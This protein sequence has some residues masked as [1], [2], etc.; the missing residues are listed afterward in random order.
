MPKAKVKKE[1]L[2]REINISANAAIDIEPAFKTEYYCDMVTLIIGIG[3]DETADLYMTTEAWEALK[4]G[5]K[6][7]IEEAK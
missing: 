7:Y 6:L 1:V 4:K 5:E 2:G 3:K